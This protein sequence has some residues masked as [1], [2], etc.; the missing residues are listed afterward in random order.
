MS[1]KTIIE[2]G[3]LRNWEFRGMKALWFGKHLYQ[4]LLYLEQGIVEISPVP[5]NKG[6]NRLCGRPE[7]IL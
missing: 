3:T 1:L 7:N 2:S 5:L 6:E 4:P